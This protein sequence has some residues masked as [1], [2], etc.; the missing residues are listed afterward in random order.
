MCIC[1][2]LSIA[3]QQYNATADIVVGNIRQGMDR[4]YN[5]GARKCAFDDFNRVHRPSCKSGGTIKHL[6][7]G[8]LACATPITSLVCHTATPLCTPV[9]QQLAQP[10]GSLCRFLLLNEPDLTGLPAFTQTMY[11]ASYGQ[12]LVRPTINYI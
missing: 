7:A 5:A 3:L 8:L 12:I 4:L 11:Q 6:S 1:R 2:Y 10:L 9:R